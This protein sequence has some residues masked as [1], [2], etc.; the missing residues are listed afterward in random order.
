M[1]A[2]ASKGEIE[3]VLGG[4]T[5]VLCFT[6]GDIEE[7]EARLG[8]GIGE[9]SRRLA[10]DYRLTDL[11]TLIQISLTNAGWKPKADARQEV[12]DMI[13]VEGPA[14]HRIT[15][16][17][18]LDAALGELPGNAGAPAGTDGANASTDSRS[19]ASSNLAA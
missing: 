6:I 10:V 16:A 1:T 7:A 19:G 18:L 14:A 15:C 11:R 8:A 9:I 5:R 13:R 12:L 3:A 17:K 2:I 4:E